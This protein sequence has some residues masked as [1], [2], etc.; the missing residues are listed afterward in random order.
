[1]YLCVYSLQKTLFDGECE[2]LIAHTPQGQITVLADH[3]PL[4]TKLTG[5]QVITVDTAGK[6]HEIGLDRGI[7]EVRPGSEV[8]ILVES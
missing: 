5:P 6:R 8:V 2:K 1:M 3:L 7:L 4:I